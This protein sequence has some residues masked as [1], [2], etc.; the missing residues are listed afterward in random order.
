MYIS[1]GLVA[2]VSTPPNQN[3]CIRGVAMRTVS[4]TVVWKL[5]KKPEA[6]NNA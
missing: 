1:D 6:N 2:G 5:C 4:V 3:I